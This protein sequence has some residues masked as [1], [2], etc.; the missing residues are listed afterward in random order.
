VWR[1]E[2]S[3]VVEPG[4][5]RKERRRPPPEK[6]WERK[7]MYW[8]ERIYARQVEAVAEAGDADV[9]D[10]GDCFGPGPLMSHHNSVLCLD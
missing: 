3:V 2:R 5:S 4:R 8:R 7:S 1:N 10:V 6:K 9:L